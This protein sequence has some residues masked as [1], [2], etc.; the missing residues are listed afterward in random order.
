MPEYYA[1]D[2]PL[3][4]SYGELVHAFS[5]FHVPVYQRG[6]SWTDIQV[7]QLWEDLKQLKG[8]DGDKDNTF[9]GTLVFDE[10]PKDQAGNACQIIDGQQR[11]T[12]LFLFCISIFRR[13]QNLD[14]VKGDVQAMLGPFRRP[15]WAQSNPQEI[16]LLPREPDRK[17]LDFLLKELN[18]DNKIFLVTDAEGFNERRWEELDTNTANHDLRKITKVI[19]QCLS[20]RHGGL[21]QEQE[22]AS[23]KNL[24]ESIT[25]RVL[26]CVITLDPSLDPN[27]VFERLNDAGE[28]LSNYDL[29][30]NH[31]M[32]MTMEDSDGEM[33]SL[34]SSET[35]YSK[36]FE[37]MEKDWYW[38]KDQMQ[39][40]K[41][42]S[43][44]RLKPYLFSLARIRSA[45]YELEAS[46]NKGL[47][48]KP[49]IKGSD[50]HVLK[51]YYDLN[52]FNSEYL[53]GSQIAREN[54]F[55]EAIHDLY[56]YKDIFSALTR[57][58]REI[59]S[60]QLHNPNYISKLDNDESEEIQKRIR[61]FSSFKV[62][63]STFPYLLVLFHSVITKSINFKSGIELLDLI[64]SFLV[65]RQICG[66]IN[67][68][69]EI[70][71][72]LMSV[73]N[74]FNQDV[75][76]AAIKEDIQ[77]S[78]VSNQNLYDFIV[79]KD[80]QSSKGIYNKK[81]TYQFLIEEYDIIV[82][83][84]PA[85]YKKFE[86]DHVIP[87][88][89]EDK[90]DESLWEGWDREQYNF[91]LHKWANLVPLTPTGNKWKNAEDFPKAKEIFNDGDGNNYSSAA[92]VFALD[93]WTPTEVKA[94]AAQIAN[95]IIKRWP[96]P[97]SVQREEDML[98]IIDRIDE[99]D[100]E[101]S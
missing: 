49:I 7:N 51:H 15:H 8:V 42:I 94:R 24:Y 86:V 47:K 81:S 62:D 22:I 14:L 35:I 29:L 9:L 58:V 67:K 68:S 69:V 66:F 26:F 44:K 48:E 21:S 37:S 52:F 93:N 77:D 20:E 80:P 30:R 63:N 54:I 31:L 85:D 16:K 83:G 45:E 33:I 55:N 50:F 89:L 4:R 17:C 72:D 19:D 100:Y 90:D 79:G 11:I 38:I 12:T 13:L 70:F 60:D 76:L 10:G 39:S 40:A 92:E 74:K 99:D 27:E 57:E 43:S 73:E 65:R 59:K 84:E 41:R 61:R 101:A 82:E 18:D 46:K 87:Q 64:E 56:E 25:E 98:G 28:P 6:F 34:E 32:R 23:L 88:A 53:E 96:L 78:W 71:R 97:D 75:V 91:W 95:K 2:Q 5:R 36:Y 3:I 1:G